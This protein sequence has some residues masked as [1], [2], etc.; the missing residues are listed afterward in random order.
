MY[1]SAEFLETPLS[2]A[3]TKESASAMIITLVNGGALLDYRTKQGL[4]AVHRAAAAGQAAS[5]KVQLYTVITIHLVH[6]SRS[7]VLFTMSH[8]DPC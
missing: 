6:G 4:T 5:V 8:F 2:M 3:A 1:N 7:Y